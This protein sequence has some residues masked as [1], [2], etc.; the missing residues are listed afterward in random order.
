MS[1]YVGVCAR[2]CVH[3]SISFHITKEK[4]SLLKIYRLKLLL[5]LAL[6]IMQLRQLVL[7]KKYDSQ[8]VSNENHLATN[9]INFNT[10]LY[11]S[12]S[13]ARAELLKKESIRRD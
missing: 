12:Y 10:D 9:I 6:Q 3:V 13:N 1:M 5:S 8:M 2:A 4:C 11:K 7:H